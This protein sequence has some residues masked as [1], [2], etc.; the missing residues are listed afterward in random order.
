MEQG[1]PINNTVANSEFSSDCSGRLARQ[2]Q[3]YAGSRCRPLTRWITL[4]LLSGLELPQTS[5]RTFR[6][7]LCICLWLKYWHKCVKKWLIDIK[8]DVLHGPG[9]IHFYGRKQM[10]YANFFAIPKTSV[11]NLCNAVRV[12]RKVTNFT[13]G[14]GVCTHTLYSDI[15]KRRKWFPTCFEMKTKRVVCITQ[16]Y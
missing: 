7:F 10:W 15:H 8:E 14:I 3:L 5:L 13:I 2:G 12:C 6:V 9:L 16:C 11:T 1:E 4:M